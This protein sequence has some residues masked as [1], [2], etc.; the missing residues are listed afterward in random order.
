MGGGYRAPWWLRNGHVN[1]IYSYLRPRPDGPP[2]PVDCWLQLD[3]GSRGLLRA[4]WQPRPAPALLLAHGLEGSSEAG[5]MMTLAGK[6]WRRG[7]HAVRANIRG[8]GPSEGHCDTL[9][10]S[11]L[12]DDVGTWVDWLLEQPNVT[13]I[14]LA[15]FS[16]GGNTIL[17][18]LGRRGEAAPARLKA[19]ATVGAA[20]DLGPSA[21]R[22]HARSN[23]FYEARFLR[24]LKA[25]LRRQ[26][27]RHPGRFRVEELRRVDSVRA[28][29][30]L[31]TAP[32]YGF[33][34]ADDYYHRASAARVVDRIRVPTLVLHAEDDPFV[35]ITP[36]TR[37][38]LAAN[39]AIEFQASQHGGHCAFIARAIPGQ[40]CYWAE[41]RIVDFCGQLL[42]RVDR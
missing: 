26:A 14:A 30:E 3:P 17:R 21:D 12:S 1:T 37:A 6:A 38:L 25:R 22:L 9:Y 7:W 32:F 36:E 40:D 20:I 16:M 35:V 39:P 5:Y 18:Y 13:D 8:C 29:D 11:G 24:G 10:N 2:H 34:G 42:P 27:A 15:G 28:F 19:A 31:I 23:R 4:H 33:A 41:Q